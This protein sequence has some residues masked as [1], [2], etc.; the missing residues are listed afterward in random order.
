MRERAPVR[1]IALC[2]FARYAE[3]DRGREPP[4]FARSLPRAATLWS[5]L[6]RFGLRR[7]PIANVRD[8]SDDLAEMC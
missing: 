7:A 4:R 1:P 8:R 6:E 3:A 2:A 5:V